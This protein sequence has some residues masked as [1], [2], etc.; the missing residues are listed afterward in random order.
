MFTQSYIHR[1]YRDGYIVCTHI[2]KENNTLKL[3]IKLPINIFILMNEY[4]VGR[5]KN[6]RFPT[7][8]SYYIPPTL[9]E[10]Q[11]YQ[12]ISAA[13]E[14]IDVSRNC[15]LASYI[16]PISTFIEWECELTI[17]ELLNFI[18]RTY[19]KKITNNFE[20]HISKIFELSDISKIFYKILGETF[21]EE[22]LKFDEEYS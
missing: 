1:I 14:C 8:A 10:R 9:T 5:F 21:P 7:R 17:N 20:R 19:F 6:F 3:S 12:Y 4:F 18:R 2:C 13:N 11:E 15:E 16:L 22:K